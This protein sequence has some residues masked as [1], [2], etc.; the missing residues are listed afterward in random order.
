M[1][2]SILTIVIAAAALLL[3]AQGTGKSANGVIPPPFCPPFCSK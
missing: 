2:K 3:S 1:T